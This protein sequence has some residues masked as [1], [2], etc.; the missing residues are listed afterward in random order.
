MNDQVEEVKQKVDIV[1]LIGE[2][3]ELKKAGRNYKALC[4]FHGEKSPSFIISPEL[5]IFK[6]FGCQKSGDVFS[7]LMEY[8]GMDFPEAL[9]FLA[10]KVGVRLKT[11][12]FGPKSHKERLYQIN[13]MASRFYSFILLS[14]PKGQRAL[15][16]L[17]ETRGLDIE[18]IKTFR[19]GF[20]PENSLALKKFLV[21][22]KN[23]AVSDLEKAGLVYKKN[24]YP[25]DRFSGRVT[26]P[27]TDHRGNIVGFSGR[28][29]PSEEKKDLA[30]YINTP[31]TEIYHKSKVLYGLDL[32]RFEIK[33]KNEALI[34]EGEL[35]VISAWQAGVRN[36]VAIKGSSLT[37]DQ[38]ALVKR[39][40]KKIVLALDT[41]L[42]GDEATRRAIANAEKEGIEIRVARILGFKDPDE[43]VK[44]DIKAFLL[45]IKNAVIAWDFIFES[46]FSKY[47][48]VSVAG[49]MKISKDVSPIIAAI[50]DKIVQA[51]YIELT[52]KRLK[53]PVDA[54]YAQVI[55]GKNLKDSSKAD[56]LKEVKKSP[57]SRISIL[58]EKIFTLAFS[59]DPRILLNPKVNSLISS[60]LLTR[61][62]EEMVKYLK[63]EKHF[64]PS[65]FADKLPKELVDGFIDLVLKEVKVEEEESYEKEL[66]LVVKELKIAKL[67]ERLNTLVRNIRG[68]ENTLQKNKLKKAQKKFDFLRKKL[69]DLEKKKYGDIIV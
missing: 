67:K 39:F 1:S 6:C 4:P 5:Q 30:K 15:N 58:E 36:V 52:A 3:L 65:V 37:D 56:F 7:F 61:I 9:K 23:Y 69:T 49:K 14:H 50:P 28:I 46:V 45:F 55:G 42:A 19:L 41:D 40:T 66:A 29:L 13:E 62:I 26:F 53:V 44:K 25:Y 57:K 48:R 32:S 18:T 2:H 22:K 31:E 68:L 43:A 27:L 60:P 64:D 59:H 54:V 17:K 8:E 10:E 35:D 12:S 16:Y 34:M 63:K 51:H 24:G 33:K 21:E 11:S 20:S 47:D 38:I